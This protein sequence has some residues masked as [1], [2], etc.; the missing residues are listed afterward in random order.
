MAASKIGVIGAGVMGH[1]I[2]QVAG[3]S[4]FSVV[5]VDIK[6]ELVENGLEKIK[7]FLEEGVKRG[8]IVKEDVSLI[9][10]RIIGTTDLKEVSQ[11]DLVCHWRGD[12]PPKIPKG[13]GNNT[14][15][16]EEARG[17]VFIES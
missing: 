10:G 3:Q 16:N 7:K 6:T 13:E 15:G 14:T 9:V 4:G 12:F 2:A 5:L 17:N 8:K 11:A 1:G